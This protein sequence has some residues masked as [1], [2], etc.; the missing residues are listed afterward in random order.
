MFYVGYLHYSSWQSSQ[1]CS[2]YAIPVWLTEPA[3]AHCESYACPACTICISHC[4]AYQAQLVPW[5]YSSL[6][7]T[8]YDLQ[9]RLSLRLYMRKCH[10]IQVGFVVGTDGILPFL[11]RCLLEP[12]FMLGT[13]VVCFSAV[14]IMF[15]LRTLEQRRHAAV[16][17]SSMHHHAFTQT[18]HA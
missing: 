7:H 3:M 2:L 18:A 13:F 15:E 14:Q 8:V 11:Q 1:M 17:P 16:Q 9:W 5:S 6:S 12:W 10:L 4:C